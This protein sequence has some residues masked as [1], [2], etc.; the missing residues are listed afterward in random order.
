MLNPEC[1]V[2]GV[3]FSLPVVIFPSTVKECA[4]NLDQEDDKEKLVSALWGAERCLRVL[5][6]VSVKFETKALFVLCCFTLFMDQNFPLSL[7]GSGFYLQVTVH[8]PENQSYLI[9][10]KDSSLIVSSAK[11][12]K[13]H[14]L[15]TADDCCVDFNAC[16]FTCY[17]EMDSNTEGD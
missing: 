12:V 8:N 6:S 3:W 10:Y 9:A 7:K 2:S 4:D 16:L 15:P 17:N 11:W 13:T 1:Y 14:K 5:E